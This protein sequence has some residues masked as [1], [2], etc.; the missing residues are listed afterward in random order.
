[1]PTDGTQGN[2]AGR[3]RKKSQ[4]WVLG[5]LATVLLAALTAAASG[6]GSKA[7]DALTAT[8]RPPLSYS[9]EEQGYECGSVTYLSDPRASAVRR[10]TPPTNWHAFQHQP[11]AAFASGD[12]VQISIQGE[13]ARKVTLT[14]IRF[15]VKRRK[16][17]PGA[18]FAASCGGPVTGRGLE[19]DMQANPPR[20]IGSSSEMNGPVASGGFPGSQTA[21]IRFPWT[22]SLRD[23]LLL[24]VIATA[25]SC[26]CRWGAEIPW[27]SGAERGTIQID[28][29]GQ[30]YRVV[31]EEG[32]PG[33][34]SL[35]SEWQLYTQ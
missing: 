31:G 15:S 12:V 14:G 16:R 32:L 13:S 6:L 22:V 25:K 34:S 33:Y 5:A 10:S 17:R 2:D 9:A 29:G 27:V 1:V 21:P 4:K 11:G 18:T 23:P 35:N 19:V 26:D 30:R 28:N 3:G 7:V 24:Y 8:S 20:I